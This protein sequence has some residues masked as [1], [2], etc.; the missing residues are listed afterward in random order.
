MMSYSDLVYYMQSLE[1]FF[2]SYLLDICWDI[3]HTVSIN[4]TYAQNI[5]GF[6]R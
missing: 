3:I 4:T 5:A 1:Y 6:Y 2:V